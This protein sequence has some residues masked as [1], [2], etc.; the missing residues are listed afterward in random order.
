MATLLIN[1]HKLATGE[2]PATIYAAHT[3]P[4][5]GYVYAWGDTTDSTVIWFLA[6]CPVDA[7]RTKLTNRMTGIVSNVYGDQQD[8]DPHIRIQ[9]IIT[10]AKETAK[11][12]LAQ[13]RQ[14]VHHGR[15][16]LV[17]LQRALSLRCGALVPMPQALNAQPM[18]GIKPLLTSCVSIMTQLAPMPPR[19]HSLHGAKYPRCASRGHTARRVCWLAYRQRTRHGHIK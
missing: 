16:M 11:G 5:D 14:P 8:P 13:Q 7:I 15:S 6:T 4:L 1:Y 10:K 2:D 3:C 9:A 17:P 12:S 19:P 18:T